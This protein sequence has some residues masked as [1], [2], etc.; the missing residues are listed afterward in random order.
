[1]IDLALT[2]AA[3]D[4]M[5]FDNIGWL[6]TTDNITGAFAKAV[7]NKRLSTLL[8]DKQLPTRVSQW[9]IRSRYLLPK[10]LLAQKTPDSENHT[11]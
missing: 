5:K 2:R 10:H 8:D 9:I 3:Y 7:V 11:N 4:T 1:M 6:R